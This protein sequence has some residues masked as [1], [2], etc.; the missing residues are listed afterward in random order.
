MSGI[1][2]IESVPTQRGK[3]RNGLDQDVNSI[4]LSVVGFCLMLFLFSHTY[5]LE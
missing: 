4:H 5:I 1:L 2:Q 3:Q